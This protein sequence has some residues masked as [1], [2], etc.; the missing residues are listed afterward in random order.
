MAI[1]LYARQSVERENSMSC[2]TQ[3]EYCRSMLRPEERGEELLCLVDQGFSGGNCRRQGFQTLMDGVRQGKVSKVIVYKVDRLSRSLLDFVRTLQ[4][5]KEQGVQFV[6]SQEAFDTSTAYG[7]LILKILV[8]FAEFERNSIIDRISQAYQYRSDMGLYM[9]GRR[10]FG[11]QLLP[12][13]LHGI[14]SKQLSPLPEEAA[15]VRWLYSAYA[16]NDCSLRS[17]LEPLEQR[18]SLSW[19][20]SRLSALLRNPLYVQADWRVY[21]YY[22]SKGVDIKSPC[23][24][25]QGRCGAQLYQQGRKGTSS[26]SGQKLVLLGHEG[27]VPAD[28]W[29]HCQ[30]KLDEHRRHPHRRDCRS[31]LCGSLYCGSCGRPLRCISGSKRKDG[32]QRRYFTCPGHSAPSGVETA[33]SGLPFS[34]YAEDAENLLADAVRQRLQQL[35]PTLPADCSALSPTLLSLKQRQQ[36]IEQTQQQLVDRM[37]ASSPSPDLLRLLSQRAEQLAEEQLQIQ[38]QLSALLEKEVDSAAFD[39]L[40]LWEQ[41]DK[42]GKQAAFSLLAKQVVV[43]ADGSLCVTWQL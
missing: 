18:F 43:E 36:Q 11:F 27:L 2:E 8:V 4:I 33:C 12:C 31:W 14:P 32:T 5:F 25:F 23:S 35:K 40:P 34:L 17:L 7:E 3:L 10:P 30:R 15:A 24:A 28:C 29:L 37:L 38:R 13:Q 9:G 16:E 41:A 20:S 6:S 22:Q 19:S 39:L 26:A 42:V 21:D 1:V